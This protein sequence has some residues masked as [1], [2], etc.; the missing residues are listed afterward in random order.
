MDKFVFKL[1]QPL[2]NVAT[3]DGNS[4]GAG[5]E[6]AEPKNWQSVL[7]P[8]G[9]NAQEISQE[10][11]LNAILESPVISSRINEETKKAT[12]KAKEEFL[13]NA[14][15]VFDLPDESKIRSLDD[16]KGAVFN[17]FSQKL[18]VKDSELRTQ[19]EQLALQN[20]N[21]ELKI[22]ELS[23]IPD[24]LKSEFETELETNRKK[25]ELD[26]KIKNALQRTEFAQETVKTELG[27]QMHSEYFFK[28]LE[29]NELKISS[30]KILHA[31]DKKIDGFPVYKDRPYQI[32]NAE[33]KSVDASLQDVVVEYLESLNLI[34][35]NT[36]TVTGSPIVAGHEVPKKLPL[37]VQQALA[38]ARHS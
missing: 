13:A 17:K 15:S 34:K 33:K 29:D 20:K 11:A 6:T 5:S 35:K 14:R 30:D 10:N 12:E 37:H 27:L 2:L 16:L 8:L 24:K 21:Y 9:I 4:G 26:S 25:W 22:E 32:K 18:E 28:Y 36:S 23:K 31:K 38:A 1:P 3:E 19:N 7:E